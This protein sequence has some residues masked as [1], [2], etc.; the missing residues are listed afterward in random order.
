VSHGVERVEGDL[1]CGLV[2]SSL[3]GV[4]KSETVKLV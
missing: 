4:I 2:C 3:D 1:G